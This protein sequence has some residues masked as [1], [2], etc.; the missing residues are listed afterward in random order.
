MSFTALSKNAR[1]ISTFYA[2][3]KVNIA[4]L[5]VEASSQALSAILRLKRHHPRMAG[6]FA[7]IDV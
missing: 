5:P 7:E 6:I 1:L 3:H 2:E 4:G